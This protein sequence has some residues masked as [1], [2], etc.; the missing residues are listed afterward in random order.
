MIQYQITFSWFLIKNL[1]SAFRL[2]SGN[3]PMLFHANRDANNILR[4]TWGK[5]LTIAA[6]HSHLVTINGRYIVSAPHDP[7]VTTMRSL[8]CVHP[9]SVGN[10]PTA[11]LRFRKIWDCVMAYV[12]KLLVP[13][14]TGRNENDEGNLNSNG[15]EAI[16]DQT[17]AFPGCKQ[18]VPWSAE[19]CSN[20]ALSLALRF[21]RMS[22]L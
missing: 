15:W 11:N 1:G 12:P 5:R 2:D 18:C 4:A 3:G 6:L 22:R 16:Q 19:P 10:S 13:L 17:E 9:Q 8:R 21:C 20:A 14:L 7:H